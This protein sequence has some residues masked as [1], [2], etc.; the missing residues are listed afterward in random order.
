MYLLINHLTRMRQGFMCTAGVNL[1]TGQHVRPVVRK[2][3]GIDML[4]RHGG[5]FDI[6]ALV[7]LGPTLRVGQPPELEDYRFNP[8]KAARKGTA[9]GQLLWDWQVRL[10]RSTLTELFG[11]ELTRRGA[12]SCAV[13][14][15]QGKASL[16]CWASPRCA[17]LYMAPRPDRPPQVR[18][19][20]SDGEFDLDLG[21]TDIRLYGADHVTPDEAAVS[22]V[23]ERLRAGEEVILTV[24][25]TRP[26]PPAPGQP[27]VHWLQVNN[28][29]FRE[30]QIWQLG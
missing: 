26:P 5:P 7:E 12:H 17:E 10:A 3:L 29:H 14:L 20:A 13:D 19:R 28:F 1:A 15:H 9:S 22:R 4:A 25:L 21:V 16:G 30:D 6:G 24:G 23:R 11:N 27:Q 2:Q 18:L 8:K